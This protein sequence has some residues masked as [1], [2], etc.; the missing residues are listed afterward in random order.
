MDEKFDDPVPHEMALEQ[1]F[2]D[3]DTRAWLIV[4]GS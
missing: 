4:A 2:I 3:G 1:E